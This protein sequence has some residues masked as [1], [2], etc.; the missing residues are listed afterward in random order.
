MIDMVKKVKI[1]KVGN[2]EWSFRS[3]DR[4]KKLGKIY[5]KYEDFL[6]MIKFQMFYKF[7][8]KIMIFICCKV[9]DYLKLIFFSMLEF[10]KYSNRF[11]SNL[12]KL[13]VFFLA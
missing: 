12:V 11:N 6:S 10:G 7:W 13:L 1:L 4:K 8:F 3:K 5:R 2:V 9:N